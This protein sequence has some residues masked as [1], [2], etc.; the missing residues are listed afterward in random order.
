MSLI[1]IQNNIVKVHYR[2]PYVVYF[3]ILLSFSSKTYSKLKEKKMYL[4]YFNIEGTIK[5]IEF[6]NLINKI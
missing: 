5:Y 2:I 1:K 6:I 3:E 4:N